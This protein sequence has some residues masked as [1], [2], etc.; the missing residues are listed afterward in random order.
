MVYEF[1]Y[2]AADQLLGAA[3][4]STGPGAALLKQYV[5]GYDKAGNRTSEQISPGP[6]GGFP[7]AV[8]T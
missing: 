6:G 4:K 3:L 7:T 8:A 1:E 5:Y 2:D